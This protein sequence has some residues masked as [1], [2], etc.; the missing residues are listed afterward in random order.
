MRQLFLRVLKMN[1]FF[2]IFCILISHSLYALTGI[3][4]FYSQIHEGNLLLPISQRPTPFWSFGQTIADKNDFLGW[5]TI[6]DTQGKQR[7]EKQYIQSVPQ[8]LY[9]PL[10]NLAL[11]IQPP[12]AIKYKLGNKT[13]SG[14]EDT[15]VQFEY[16]YART[17]KPTSTKRATVVAAINLPTGSAKKDPPTGFGSPSFFFGLTAYTT[18]IDWYAYLSPGATFTTQHKGTKYGN[19]YV[20]QFGLGH[21]VHHLQKWILCL[22]LEANGTYSEKNKINKKIDPNS[23]GNVFYMGPVFFASSKRWIFKL[24]T[25]FPVS[26]HLFGNQPKNKFMIGGRIGM[27][28]TNVIS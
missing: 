12:Q 18:T 17:V 26:Q 3:E 22:F 21:N 16:D 23:G 14:F 28:F 4:N 5:E 10:Y 7:K 27:K 20:Y 25:Q 15:L 8:M 19:Q 24:G 6:Q 2:I 11:F 9:A 1:I 13:S